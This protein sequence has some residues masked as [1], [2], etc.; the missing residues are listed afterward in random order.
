MVCVLLLAGS[1]DC[2]EL[3]KGDGHA[4]G[5][6]GGLQICPGWHQ[7]CAGAGWRE[8]AVEPL[9]LSVYPAVFAV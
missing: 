1:G 7:D 4:F 5:G 9:P 3:G 2:V 8:R 6:E